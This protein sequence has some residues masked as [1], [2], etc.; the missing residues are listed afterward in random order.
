VPSTTQ[1]T[2]ALDEIDAA[3]LEVSGRNNPLTRWG[4]IYSPHV[5]ENGVR[6][7]SLERY[8]RITLTAFTS[9]GAKGITLLTAVVVVPLTFRYLGPERYGLWMTITSFV[10]FLGFAD[11]GIGNGL[12]A[13]I[14]ESHGQE[15]QAE[16]AKCVSCAFYFLLPLSAILMLVF[17]GAF[18]HVSWQSVYG[19]RSP[20]AVREAGWATA[21]LLVCSA[22]NMPLGTA[23]RVELGYQQGY[24][25]DIWNASGSL[26]AL[27]GIL[28]VVKHGGGLPQLVLAVAALPLVVNAVNWIVQFWFIRPELR[29]RISL[30]DIATARQL[31][32]IGG[33]FFVQQCFGLIYYLS[34]NIVIARTMGATEVARYAVLQRIFSIGLITQYFVAPLWPAI[35]EAV[36]RHD[37]HWAARTARRALAGILLLGTVCSV[38]L[39]M[40]SRYLMKRWSGVDPGPIDSLRIGF[41]VWVVLVGYIATMNALLNQRAVMKFHV[42]IFGLASL[43]SLALKLFF[44]TH[45]SIAGVIWATNIGFGV[46]YVVPAAVLSLRSL[47][48]RTLEAGR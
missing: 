22:L 39:L 24:V 19:V 26:L 4:A 37:L 18:H 27:A 42:L 25:A 44:A 30:F 45:G 38:S 12:T 47:S 48:V 10:L 2:K 41:A 23:L 20:L 46:I 29:P 3:E 31:F 13:R 9:L 6:R 33:L 40:A 5:A 1:S 32:A 15:N 11:L 43:T 34:D 7:R 28:F 8:R 17:A 16:A 14:A 36:A 35:S 21:V